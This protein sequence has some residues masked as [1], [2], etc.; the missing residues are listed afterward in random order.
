MFN[1]KLFVCISSNEITAGQSVP[2]KI[3]QPQ[4]ESNFCITHRQSGFLSAYLLVTLLRHALARYN[5]TINCSRSTYSADRCIKLPCTSVSLSQS[6]MYHT[7]KFC[8]VA[9]PRVNLIKSLQ[10]G[11]SKT[12]NFSVTIFFDIES[13]QIYLRCISIIIGLKV[14]FR[15]QF[16]IE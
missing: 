14:A 9:I 12:C 16:Q 11:F 1:W 6:F 3:Q 13:I 2:H 7:E 8:F 10:S 15:H 4:M 5:S